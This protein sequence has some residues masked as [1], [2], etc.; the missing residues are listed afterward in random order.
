II[1]V[2]VAT[3]LYINGIW[4]DFVHDDLSA[5]V[6]NP[7]V[8]GTRPI[9]RIFVNDFWG[10]PMKDPLSHKSYRPL[11]IL[12][13]RWSIM[14]FGQSPVSFHL[15]NIL[16]HVAV[17]LLYLH[18]LVSVLHFPHTKALVCG[19]IF[20]AHPIH[21]EAVT[22]IVGRADVLAA[23]TFLV[24]FNTYIRGIS[25]SKK[26]SNS[27]IWFICGV[28]CTMVGGLCKETGLTIFPLLIVWDVWLHRRYWTSF[29]K[30]GIIPQRL[31]MC[32][33]R[34]VALIIVGMMVLMF[35][36]MFMF[37]TP[38][39]SEQD[40]PAAHTDITLARVLTYL[41][42]PA[43]NTWL[44]LCP[45]QLCY[46]WQMGSVPLIM[47]L[48]DLRNAGS[49]LLYLSICLLFLIACIKKNKESNAI[50]WSLVVMIFG[51]LPAS[52]MFISVGFVIAER[53]LYIPSMGFCTIIGIG[54]SRLLNN[55][56]NIDCTHSS[57]FCPEKNKNEQND[58]SNNDVKHFSNDECKL[59]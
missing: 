16:L 53:I 39:F 56:H 43:H 6:D 2:A 46:D 28:L 26:G 1:I 8:Q 32:L 40:N 55:I 37:G 31:E 45:W 3:L 5:I 41:Y 44:M 50:I 22:G 54:A 14:L 19:L 51:F 27:N 42:L 12:T 18:T 59:D 9:W 29:I 33:K 13:F 38:V 20:A 17:S 25:R 30:W 15:V 58:N 49:L 35:R 4:G 7:D 24:S 48:D 11:T 57:E 36:V 23:F 21:T 10:K 52:N 47:K 34:N